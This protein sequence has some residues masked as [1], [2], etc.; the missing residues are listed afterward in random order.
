MLTDMQMTTAQESG[1]ITLHAG[2]TVGDLLLGLY[3]LGI[4]GRDVKFAES[5]LLW[6]DEPEGE[7]AELAEA[8]V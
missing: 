4:D 1:Q 7:L 2:Q 8:H 6:V 3:E 5:A